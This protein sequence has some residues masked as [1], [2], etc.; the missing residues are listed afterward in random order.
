MGDY[1]R[2]KPPEVRAKISASLT[3]KTQSA[4]TRAKRGE[5]LRQAYTEGRKPKPTGR[6]PG[7]TSM[8]PCP[9]CGRTMKADRLP[10]HRCRPT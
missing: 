8:V 1:M 9:V 7:P 10:R 2:S 4:A 5:S 3:G 6:P